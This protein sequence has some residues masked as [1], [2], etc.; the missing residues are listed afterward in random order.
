MSKEDFFAGIDEA[1]EQIKNGNCKTMQ[2]DENQ[3][4]FLVRNGYV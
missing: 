4:D 3:D 2:Q 1:K